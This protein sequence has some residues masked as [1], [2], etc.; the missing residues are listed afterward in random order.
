MPIDVVRVTVNLLVSRAA[1]LRP[2]P[3]LLVA[4]TLALATVAWPTY[5]DAMPAFPTGGL[6]DASAAVGWPR[7]AQG[8]ATRISLAEATD[9]VQQATGGRILDARDD[10]NLYRIKVVTRQGEVRVVYV[11]PRTGAMR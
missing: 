9:R 7:M 8:P 11:D 4:G 10:G 1:C 5:V 2:L 6:H 3:G